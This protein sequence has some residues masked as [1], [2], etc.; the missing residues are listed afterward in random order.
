MTF[1]C[2]IGLQL[3]LKIIISVIYTRDINEVPSN[4]LNSQRTKYRLWLG[5]WNWANTVDSYQ[6]YGGISDSNDKSGLF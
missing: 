6:I 4:L 2:W 1:N 3:L 5:S